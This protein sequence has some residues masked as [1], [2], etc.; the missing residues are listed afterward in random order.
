L[1]DKLSSGSIN[2]RVAVWDGW[3]GMAITLLLMGHFTHIPW[4]WEDRL[5]VDAFFVLSGML[6]S[7]ILFEKRIPLKTFYIRRFSRIFP[8]FSLYIIVAF[9][10][11]YV[12][13]TYLGKADMAFEIQEF[14]ST[15]TFFRTYYPLDP[16]IWATKVPIGHLWSLNVEE[17]AYVLMSLLT[18]FIFRNKKVAML[19]ITLGLGAIALSFYYYFNIANAPIEFRIRTETAISFIFLSAGYNLIKKQ[20]NITIPSLLPVITLAL[21]FA[22]YLENPSLPAGISG[23]KLLYPWLSFSVAPILLAFSLNH[24]TEIHALFRKVFELKAIRLMGTWSFSI[25]LWQQLFYSYKWLIPFQPVGGI[26]VSI[27]VGALSFYL[28]ENPVRRWINNRWT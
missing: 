6:M 19:L 12:S 5:G 25:Y 17:H 24:V 7:T 8:V 14:F 4:I 21:A 3:R 9:L 18:L 28:F 26:M 15:L 27:I 11:A 13:K 20:F 23:R 22:C 10:L 1:S 2:N 16:H